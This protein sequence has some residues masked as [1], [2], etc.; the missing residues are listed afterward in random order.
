MIIKSKFKFFDKEIIVSPIKVWQYKRLI[1]WD[2]A[3]FEEIFWKDWKLMCERQQKM[4][5]KILLWWYTTKTL[6]SML[7]VNKS[8]PKKKKK[9]DLLWKD[10]NILEWKI[11]KHLNQQLNEIRSWDF[12]YFTKQL[13]D[14]PV[15]TEQVSYLDH[16]NREKPDKVGMKKIKSLLN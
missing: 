11:M 3:V 13:E 16:K 1:D 6:E 15:I 4:A 9:N 2:E 14:L 12:L 7:T 10:F 8:V 5:F